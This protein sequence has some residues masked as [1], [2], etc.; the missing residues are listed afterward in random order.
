MDGLRMHTLKFAVA[1]L[2]LA[3]CFAKVEIAIEGKHG[4]AGDLPTWRLPAAH[5]VSRLFFAGRA[6]TGYHVW[7]QL[8]VLSVFHL[9][10]LFSPASLPTELQILSFYMLFWVI[11][12]F[13]WFVL[14]PDFGL[15][16]FAKP[17][18]PWH[19]NWWLFAPTEY[20]IFGVAGVALYLFAL[21]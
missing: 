19:P 3:F 9:T 17:N 14:N 12:D 11:E 6:A 16:K 2:W 13:L 1:L 10:Y 4:W 8:F 5:W 21:R 20:F 15:K 7:L 18:I